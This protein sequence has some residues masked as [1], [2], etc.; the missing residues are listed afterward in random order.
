MSDLYNIEQDNQTVPVQDCEA[1]IG[2]AL[3]D[4]RALLLDALPADAA[5]VKIKAAYEWLR[6]LHATVDPAY[7]TDEVIDTMIY[8]DPVNYKD[9]AVVYSGDAAYIMYENENMAYYEPEQGTNI[10][11][12]GMVIPKNASCPGLA[13][14]FINYILTYDASYDNSITVGY[15][16]GNKEVKDDIANGEYDGID[17][18]VPRSGYEKDE[19]FRYNDVLVQKLS[20]LWNKVKID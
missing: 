16:S 15:T 11:S 19:V 13:N 9:L 10:W 7:G 5:Y 20:D 14:A 3:A 18:Y 4:F 12:D 2:E 6:E 1:Q 8:P 17:A